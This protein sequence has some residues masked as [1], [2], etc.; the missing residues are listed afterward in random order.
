MSPLPSPCP[1]PPHGR[2]RSSAAKVGIRKAL[3]LRY[4]SKALRFTQ[5]FH[6]GIDCLKTKNFY[7]RSQTWLGP[8]KLQNTQTDWKSAKKRKQPRRNYA[9]LASHL[10]TFVVLRSPPFVLLRLPVPHNASRQNNITRELKNL[11]ML[12][13]LVSS[14]KPRRGSVVCD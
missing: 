1:P 14:R 5:I 3:L 12:F 8:W 9:S 11:N 13:V 6:V 7:T 4:L 10:L 2:L